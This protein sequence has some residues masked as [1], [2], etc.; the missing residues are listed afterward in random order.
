MAIDDDLTIE[1]ISNCVY[2][3][4][5]IIKRDRPQWLNETARDYPWEDPNFKTR[6]I[7]KLV[8]KLDLSSDRDATISQ[9]IAWL[10]GLLYPPFFISI[11]FTNLLEQIRKYTYPNLEIEA[12]KFK[13]ISA[14]K[15]ESDGSY[16]Q[17]NRDK[18]PFA[19]L[20]LDAENISLDCKLEQIL[21]NAC[22]YPL[23]MKFAFANW[24]S[25]GKKDWDFHRRGY[26]LIHVPQ[27][28]NSAD[29][30]MIA[31]GSSLSLYYP[32]AKEVFICSSDTDLNP[33]STKLQQDNLTVYRVYRRQDR[34]LI[35]N[36]S[37]QTTNSYS[38]IT[39]DRIPLLEDFISELKNSIRSEQKQT[40]K[41]WIDL[42]IIS[43]SFASKYNLSIE[44]VIAH[45]FPE[46]KVKDFFDRFK[47]DFVIHQLGNQK[48]YITIFE[49]ELKELTKNKPSQTS[50]YLG[51]SQPSKINELLDLEIALIEIVRILL[52]RS[53]LD[54]IPISNVANEFKIIYQMSVSQAIKAIKL[55]CNYTKFL[56]ERDS[57]KL[58][59]VKAVYFVAL[60]HQK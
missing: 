6:F 14:P 50:Q 48:I 34:I 17:K 47:N 22:Q 18:K 57:F 55:D 42:N 29:L 35:F 60:K 58:K 16:R 33:L 10:Q 45:Y 31:F 32:Q 5:V 2:Q 41:N 52:A 30:K 53:Q 28:K 12:Q 56:L 24:R 3:A 7:Y 37:N 4:L 59:K 40:Q 25:L 1:S 19:I 44:R 15:I 54:F 39:V 13:K 8:V 46:A 38:L 9:L 23:K 11:H 27:G 26:E 51:N 49:I 21:I 36:S 43:R 20:L